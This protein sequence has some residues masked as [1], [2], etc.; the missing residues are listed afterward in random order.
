M[1]IRVDVTNKSG[2]EIMQEVLNRV[3]SG[4]RFGTVSTNSFSETSSF[5]W[6]EPESYSWFKNGKYIGTKGKM[7]VDEWIDL[8]FYASSTDSKYSFNRGAYNKTV[9]QVVEN[10]SNNNVSDIPTPVLELKPDEYTSLADGHIEYTLTQEGRSRGFGAKKAG[11]EYIPVYI[12]VRR[13][14]R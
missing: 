12:A 5:M 10:V 14:R 8:Q 2:E 7:P 3:V 6:G 13:P 4:E 1:A 11:L 9:E